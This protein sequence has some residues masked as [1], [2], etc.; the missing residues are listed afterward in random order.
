MPHSRQ[1]QG[2]GGRQEVAQLLAGLRTHD[3]ILAA[4]H[5]QHPRLEREAR[6]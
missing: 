2:V 4:L 6:R 3:L 5:D 1:H